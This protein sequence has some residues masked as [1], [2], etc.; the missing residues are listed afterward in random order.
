MTLWSVRPDLVFCVSRQRPFH[1]RPALRLSC[2]LCPLSYRFPR[3]SSHDGVVFPQPLG[4]VVHCL[5]RRLF[6]LCRRFRCCLPPLPC[7]SVLPFICP[8]ARAQL[9]QSALNTT[10]ISPESFVPCL[11]PEFFPFC[12]ISALIRPDSFLALIFSSLT[13]FALSVSSCLPVYPTPFVSIP[14]P[15]PTPI[16]ITP[17]FPSKLTPTSYLPTVSISSRS[18]VGFPP[19]PIRLYIHPPVMVASPFRLPSVPTPAFPASASDTYLSPALPTST[20][21]TYGPLLWSMFRSCWR[22]RRDVAGGA[23]PL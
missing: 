7:H 5:F 16:S 19:P 23:A 1:L 13:S 11:Q 4:Y 3:L 18:R 20:S 2:R 9:V 8:A 21:D 12:A 10:F 14:A 22:C 15:I 6:L 17:V